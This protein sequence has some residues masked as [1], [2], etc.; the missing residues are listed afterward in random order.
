MPGPKLVW[1]TLMVVS[2][3]L[4]QDGP[5]MAFLQHDQPV[6]TLT[7]NRAEQPLAERIRLRTAHG[8]FRTVRPSP[9]QQRPLLLTR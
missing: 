9:Q 8:V 3:L 6:Q 5:K 4:Q 2:H 7:T 1:A